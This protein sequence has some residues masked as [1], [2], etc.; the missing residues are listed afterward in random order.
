MQ[1]PELEFL[2]MTRETAVPVI[3]KLALE[4]EDPLMIPTHVETTLQTD[5]HQITE[6]RT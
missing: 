6:Q 5:T 1:N 2:E 4:M 3:P